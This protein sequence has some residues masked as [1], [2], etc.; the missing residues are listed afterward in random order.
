MENENNTSTIEV[1]VPIVKPEEITYF[2][3]FKDSE[4]RIIRVERQT[5][6]EI[7]E[8]IDTF[9][10]PEKTFFIMKGTKIV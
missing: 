6:S 7:R 8:I 2:L 1:S 4:Q 10:M 3:I 9:K 5:E